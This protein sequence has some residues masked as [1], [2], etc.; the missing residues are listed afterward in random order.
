MYAFLRRFNA[1]AKV[2]DNIVYEAAFR[3]R[4]N[5]ITISLTAEEDVWPV[6]MLGQYQ[7][8]GPVLKCPHGKRPNRLMGVFEIPAKCFDGEVIPTPAFEE[9]G[10]DEHYGKLHFGLADMQSIQLRDELAIRAT[11]E[12]KKKARVLDIVIID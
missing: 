5:E 8:R 1:P 11:R 12:L 3:P 7:A 6:E 9:D 4:D 10:G 2:R